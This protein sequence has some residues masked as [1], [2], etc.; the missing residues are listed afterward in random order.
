M[1][2]LPFSAAPWLLPL[3]L[4]QLQPEP[5][6]VIPPPPP[7]PITWLDGQ[8]SLV[9]GQY[10]SSEAQHSY[11]QM[12]QLPFLV[13]E[14]DY[15]AR[16]ANGELIRLQGAYIHAIA[17]RPYVLPST[18]RFV[19]KL[20]FDYY[21]AGCGYLTITSASRLVSERPR[22]GSIFSVHPVGMAVD[23]RVNGIGETCENWLNAYLLGKEALGE[24][25]ATREF[26][27]P[28]YHLVVPVEIIR[29]SVQI[30]Q[31]VTLTPNQS[32]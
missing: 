31:M 21:N 13:S 29:P 17:R 14:S 19:E 9:G 26:R 20:A 28:H 15:S 7:P 16:I 11:A 10:T 4:S 25:D 23:V 27:P 24:V 2:T 22:N 3:V 18:Y 12:K 5:L 8:A 6:P 1:G 30:A 32:D